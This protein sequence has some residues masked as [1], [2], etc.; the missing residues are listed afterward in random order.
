MED[1]KKILAEQDI[2]PDYINCDFKNHPLVNPKWNDICD[3]GISPK[4]NIFITGSCGN[5]KTLTAVCIMAAFTCRYGRGARFYNMEALY[6]QWLH[7]SRDGHPGGFAQRLQDSPL[8]II[9]D[10][11][12]GQISD[13][14]IRWLYSV[15]DKRWMWKRPVVVTTNRDSEDFRKI[16]GEAL[17]SRLC[18]GKIWQFKGKDERLKNA[19]VEEI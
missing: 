7:E 8:L 17:L 9:D 13:S 6:Q 11:G 10:M 2:P 19:Q 4:G 14:F 18:D 15:I 12:Q 1:W 16:F 3:F 5:G